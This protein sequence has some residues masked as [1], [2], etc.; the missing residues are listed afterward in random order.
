MTVTAPARDHGRPAFGATPGRA[1]LVRRLA[2]SATVAVVAAGIVLRFWATSDLW[3]DEA[4]SVH[5]ARLPPGDIPDALRQDGHPPLYYFVLHGWMALVGEGDVAVRALSG[6]FAVATL[7]LAWWAARRYDGRVAALLMLLLLASSPFA[8]RYATEA[9]MYSLLVL[10]VTVG[11]LLVDTSLRRPSPA[12]LAGVG[13]V[14]GSLLLTHYWAFYLVGASAVALL[15]AAAREPRPRRWHP[16]TWTLVAVGLGSLLFLPWLPGF[17]HQL[18]HTGTPWAMPTRPAAIVMDSLRDLGGGSQGEAR[19]LGWALGGLALLG[20]LVRRSEGWRIE[21]DFRTNPRA[22]AE[23]GVI[24][25]ALAAGTVVGFATASGF[26]T[27]YFSVLLPLFLLLVVRGARRLPAPWVRSGV[28]AALVVLGLTMATHQ[29]RTQR[30]QGGDIAR[31]VATE[32]HAGDVVVFCPD[33]LG[34][35]VDRVLPETFVERPFPEGGD[36]ARVDW[37]DYEERNA[38]ADPGAFARSVLAEAG[39]RDVWLVWRSG[40]RTFGRKCEQ[41]V[42]AFGASRPAERLVTPSDVFEPAELLRFPAPR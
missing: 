28:V 35:A 12:V 1:A 21:L 5:I 26:A 38:A 32:A 30:T 18:Q 42:G 8:V 11:W 40:Y 2:V 9:R 7:P 20:V 41:L 37:V 19:L 16:A 23:A 39:D 29:A 36:A 25:L 3:L 22:R 15:V 10:L 24:A 4:L 31:L 6:L 17:L 34:P 27:R 13:L 14:T 33:Q